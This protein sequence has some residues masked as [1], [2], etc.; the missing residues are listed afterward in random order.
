MKR[1]SLVLAGLFSMGMIMAANL[2]ADQQVSDA[3]PTAAA[4]EAL[5]KEKSSTPEELEK[6][7]DELEKK[8]AGGTVPE[9]VR[10][11]IAIARGS[12]MGPGSG[13][14]GPAQGRYSW[15]WLAKLLDVPESESITTAAF[16]GTPEIFNRLDRN[17]DGQVAAAD[18][19]WSDR[20]P[21]VQQSYI[22][23]RL[24][25]RIDQQGDGRLTRDEL[26]TFFDKV[27]QGKDF[28]RSEDLRDALIG[29]PSGFLPGDAPNQQVLIRG[30]LLGEV[31]SLNE[32]PQVDA[33][34]PD[35]ELMTQD[36]SRKIR[37]SEQIGSKPIV[38]VFGNFTCGPF[39]SFYPMVDE[40]CQRYQNEATFLA[41]YVREAH[42]SDGWLMESNTKV[43]VKVAQPQNFAERKS[44]AQQCY[45]KL[46][47]S[48]PLLVDEINDPVGNAY[49]GMPARLYV[50]DTDGKVT[51]K[52]GRGP[53]GFKS[54]EMEQAL[55]MTLLDRQLKQAASVGK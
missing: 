34:A 47:Y 24:F 41:V 39:R 32:G 25:R 2:F 37:L 18:F 16:K 50:I 5:V 48:M 9:S 38:L 6:L 27:S 15:T 7:A 55:V 36:G 52:G 30:L 26:L 40:L 12:Q 31:G 13:W 54:G 3:T 51:Y 8:Y 44:V 14:F 22:V 53:F 28:I 45:A 49:S 17:K 20:N 33:V 21:Y 35:F 42:P 29:G 19:D 4:L 11:L 23:N 10:M 1:L 46:K 43:G